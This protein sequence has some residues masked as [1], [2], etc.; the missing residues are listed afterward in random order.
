[1]RRFVFRRLGLFKEKCVSRWIFVAVVKN[2]ADMALKSHKN[3][4]YNRRRTRSGVL[5][6]S[7]DIL[8]VFKTRRRY[9]TL[10]LFCESC[11]PNVILLPFFN[12]LA[13]FPKDLLALGNGWQVLMTLSRR[14]SLQRQTSRESDG[15]CS[16]EAFEIAVEMSSGEP[17]RYSNKTL[18]DHLILSE[19]A[20][21]C[22]EPV[23][24]LY[25]TPSEKDVTVWFGVLFIRRGIYMGAVLRFTLTLPQ[26]FGMSAELPIVVFDLPVYH[27]HIDPHTHEL[28][29][30]RYFTDGWQPEKHHIYHVLLIVQRTF[31]SY[32]ADKATCK[33]P[34]AVTMYQENRDGFLEKAQRVIRFFPWEATVHE[35]LR[36]RLSGCLSES[37]MSNSSLLGSLGCSSNSFSASRGKMGFSWVSP[38]EGLYMSEKPRLLDSPELAGCDRDLFNGKF[39]RPPASNECCLKND[40][41]CATLTHGYLDKNQASSGSKVKNFLELC[42]KEEKN[43]WDDSETACL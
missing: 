16:A 20:L 13:R 1:M 25:I 42:E 6:N 32:D 17:L 40:G 38:A 41:C 39:R 28:E 36:H 2:L 4:S 31:F 7:S 12:P 5:M 27:P 18:K 24:G 23:D 21:I 3:S 29:I 22:Q 19:Y 43:G 35:P 14:F 37:Q 30:S 11:Y 10:F 9:A 15:L 8:I 26:E 34:G 33:N